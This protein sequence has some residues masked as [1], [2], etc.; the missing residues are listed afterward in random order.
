MSRRS[1][2]LRFA[3]CAAL[4]TAALLLT[5]FPQPLLGTSTARHAQEPPEVISSA[6]GMQRQ[7]LARFAAAHGGP[8]RLEALSTLAFSLVPARRQAPGENG[9]QEPEEAPLVDDDP[10]GIELRWRPDP[11]LVRVEDHLEG[12]P[13]IKISSTDV[14]R[15]WM[16]GLPT[17]LPDIVQGAQYEARLLLLYLELILGLT[18]G[19]LEVEPESP[20]TRDGVGYLCLRAQ[21]P[22]GESGGLPHVVYLHP[23]TGLVERIDAFDGATQRRVGT[24]LV[25]GYGEVT[26]EPRLPERLVF[27]DRS[28]RAASRWTFEQRRINPELAPERFQG[29]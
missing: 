4:V 20:R 24:V 17:G 16:D 27:L 14:S 26:G 1:T 9:D 5:S 11:R 25:Q 6:R 29:P 8:E 18:D 15:A 23:E 7:T 22:S 12:R 2:L 10:L 13:L 28:G 3:P 19:R 21:L